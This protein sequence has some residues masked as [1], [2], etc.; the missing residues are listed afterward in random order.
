MRKEDEQVRPGP[1][2]RDQRCDRG[3]RLDQPHADTVRHRNDIP[4]GAADDARDGDGEAIPFDDAVG[5]EN[6]DSARGVHD[7]RA[8]EGKGG[9]P[10]LL[11]EIREA[12]VELV[13]AE[14]RCVVTAQRE[15]FEIRFS[16]EIRI[17]R[18]SLK[19]V[20]AV[21]Q[22]N[23]RIARANRPDEFMPARDAPNLLPELGKIGR[24][25]V[26][27]VVVRVEN[28]HLLLFRSGIRRRNDDGE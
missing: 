13:I 3:G 18:R 10:V 12:V 16:L 20:A 9:V 22:Q 2:L 4:C 5:R 7:I 14:R 11:E 6:A 27:V 25:Q 24:Q 19:Y 28:R 15:G 21:E 23:A 8:Q 17:K 1:E 26:R